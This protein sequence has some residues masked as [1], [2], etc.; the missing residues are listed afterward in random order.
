MKADAQIVPDSTLATTPD[1]QKIEVDFRQLIGQHSACIAQSG[2]GKSVLTRKMLELALGSAVPVIV[3]DV[4]G[5]FLDLPS[6]SPNGMLIVGGEK[7][8]PEVTYKV[9][10]RQLGSIADGRASVIFDISSL[11]NGEGSAVV[12]DVLNGLMRV[13]DEHPMLVVL[14]EVHRF[15]PERGTSPSKDSV[16][17]MAKEGRKKGYSLLMATQ[18]LPDVAKAVVS[19]TRNRFFGRSTDSKD[20]D[21]AAKELGRSARELGCLASLEAGEFVIQ[22]A[23]FGGY[24]PRARILAPMTGRLDNTHVT[25]KLSVPPV[26]INRVVE[27]ILAKRGNNELPPA[28]TGPEPRACNTP[29]HLFAEASTPDEAGYEDL[30]L[31]LLQAS[32]GGLSS[33]LLALLCGASPRERAHDA[34]I[35]QLNERGIIAKDRTD[36]LRLADADAS[37]SSRARSTVFLQHQVDRLIRQLPTPERR[38]VRAFQATGGGSLKLHELRNLTRMSRFRS[39]T[40]Q[41]HRRGWLVKRKDV[42][43]IR[44]DLAKLLG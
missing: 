33:K 44:P 5:E 10:V 22:G 26:P 29:P 6:A 41:L 43:R 36:R 3:F 2:G 38:V 34:T 24:H 12:R 11:S 27:D 15:A 39:A 9:A 14:D 20:I 7:G 40:L 17:W 42:Y 1:G 13:P 30:V 32:P 21:R 25:E 37:S 16:V 18:R 4:A 19:Q 28:P 8:H 35:S 23:A 31:Q